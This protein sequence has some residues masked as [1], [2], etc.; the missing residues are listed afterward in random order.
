MKAGTEQ[1]EQ[2]GRPRTDRKGLTKQD[3][4]NRIDRTGQAE[5]ERK[6]RNDERDK[7][8]RTGG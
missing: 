3:R 4:Q 2:T 8:N 5:Q 6:N 7:Q 1:A